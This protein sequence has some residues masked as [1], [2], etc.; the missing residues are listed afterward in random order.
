MFG[1]TSVQW[2]HDKMT[3]LIQS[4]VNLVQLRVTQLAAFSKLQ[5]FACSGT[6]R[7]HVA[8]IQHNPRLWFPKQWWFADLPAAE[9]AYEQ[10]VVNGKRPPS[11]SE[12]LMAF[13]Q[14]IRSR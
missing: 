9:S 12:V 14:D 3:N 8:M 5:L 4:K 11:S 7:G 6:Y 13:V 2:A 10:W 1:L